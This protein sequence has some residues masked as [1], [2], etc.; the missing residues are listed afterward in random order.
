MIR[1]SRGARGI[2]LLAAFFDGCSPP[3]PRRPWLAA[4]VDSARPALPTP[5]LMSDLRQHSTTAA[6]ERA[7][8]G[9]YL[10]GVA[11]ALAAPTTTVDSVLHAAGARDIRRESDIVYF[12]PPDARLIRGTLTWAG[13][14]RSNAD[15]AALTFWTAEAGERVALSEISEAFGSWRRGPAGPSPYFAWRAVFTP[16]YRPSVARGRGD[17]SIL[18]AATLSNDPEQPDTRVVQLL[19]RRD[20]GDVR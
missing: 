5:H 20:P 7:S 13:D 19:L 8:L 16:N 1:C 2:A 4:T 6:P 3:P 11:D 18:V 17:V 12:R 10:R 9:T 14:A 15:L